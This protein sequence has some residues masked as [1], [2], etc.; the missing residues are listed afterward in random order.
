ML[1]GFAWANYAGKKWGS[2]LPVHLHAPDTNARQPAFS[3]AFLPVIV[4]IG[5]IAV[6]SFLLLEGSAATYT[7]FQQ[8]LAGLG[9]PVIALSIGV[10]L[11]FFA[12]R[13]WQR[14]TVGSLL[15]DA[16]ERR[17]ASW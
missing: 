13:G 10:V 8:V 6:K 15:H 12:G 11:A 1:T 14:A 4:P 7:T 3:I 17:A 9:D 5:L 2:D 16:V